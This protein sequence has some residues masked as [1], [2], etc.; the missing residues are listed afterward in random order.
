MQLS[1]RKKKILQVVIDEYINTA[2]P[3]SSKMIV[4]KYLPTVS[5][6]TVRHELS[7]LE[8]LG[9]LNQKHISG[10]RV[11]TATA[12]RLYIQELMKQYKLPKK[13]LLDIEENFTR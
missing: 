3:V 5:S 9:L 7:S 11:P 4:E 2:M 8:E 12:Y 1:E 13:L 6:A 10:G